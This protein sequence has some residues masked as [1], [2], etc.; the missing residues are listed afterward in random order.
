MEDLL[1]RCSIGPLGSAPKRA[2]CNMNVSALIGG[3]PTTNSKPPT[4]HSCA[5][6]HYSTL[7]CTI[8][9]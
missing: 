4:A 6:L 3:P 2:P 7:F 1:C 8:L 9:H 5:A